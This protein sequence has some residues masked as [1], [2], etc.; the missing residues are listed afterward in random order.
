MLHPAFD[1]FCRSFFQIEGQEFFPFFVHPKDLH[2]R[3]RARL[4]GKQNQWG[5]KM[6]EV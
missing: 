1:A 5:I 6:S 4:C 2:I 3:F